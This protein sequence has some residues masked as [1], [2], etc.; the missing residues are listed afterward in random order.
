MFL[1]RYKTYSGRLFIISL[2]CHS[3]FLE[4]LEVNE[5]V[6]LFS[7]NYHVAWFHASY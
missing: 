5:R 3:F 2:T 4:F 7:P 6:R 1:L